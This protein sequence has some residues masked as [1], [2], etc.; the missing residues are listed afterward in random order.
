MSEEKLSVQEQKRQARIQ[1]RNEQRSKKYMKTLVTREEALELAKGVAREV[2]T[3]LMQAQQG[4]IRANIVHTYAVVDLLV[5]KEI[6][7]NRDEL[8][9]YINKVVAQVND[10]EDEENGQEGQQTEGSD[11]QEA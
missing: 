2:V 11:T 5:E 9:P 3:Q 7:S 6:I 1:E 10:I 8:Q 4:A